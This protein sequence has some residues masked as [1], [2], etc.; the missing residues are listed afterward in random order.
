MERWNDGSIERVTISFPQPSLPLSSGT[1]KGNEGSGNEI[2]RL[3]FPH[4]LRMHAFKHRFVVRLD[5]RVALCAVHALN[6]YVN[7]RTNGRE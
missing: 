5:K 1:D 4:S 6:E 2:E 3:T 7:R